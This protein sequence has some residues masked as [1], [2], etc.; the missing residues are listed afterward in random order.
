MFDFTI[1]GF[2]IEAKDTGGLDLIVFSLAS[3]SA[4]D[5]FPVA[6]KPARPDTTLSVR[7]CNVARSLPLIHRI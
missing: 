6:I 1:K 5:N 2:L 7:F 3:I 4:S